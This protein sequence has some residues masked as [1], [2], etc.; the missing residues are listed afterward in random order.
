MTYVL[1]TDTLMI[2]GRVVATLQSI[3]YCETETTL[4]QQQYSYYPM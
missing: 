1:P 2:D 3:L 4:L